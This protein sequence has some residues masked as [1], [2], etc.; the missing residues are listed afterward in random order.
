[1]SN[2]VVLGSGAW[3][4]ALAMHLSR[5][6]CGSIKL[7]SRS[8]DVC[9]T[10]SN[11]RE[12]L[13]YLPGYRLAD[14][15]DVQSQLSLVLEKVDTI[16]LAVPSQA[17]VGVVDQVLNIL[18]QPD[19]L[20]WVVATKGLAHIQ[21][22]HMLISDYLSDV[23]IPTEKIAFLSG[24]C[25]AAELAAGMFSAMVCATV[26]VR[27]KE[28][29]SQLFAGDDMIIDVSDDLIGLQWCA[30]YKNIIAIANGILSE[31]MPS[32]NAQAWL[33]T[34]GLGEMLDF[35]PAMGGHRNTVCQL[36]G[37]GDLVLTTTG[38]MSRNKR[39][40]QALAKGM[41]PKQAETSIGQ[42]VEGTYA[43]KKVISL[44]QDLGLSLPL[45]E[46]MDKILSGECQVKSIIN[47]LN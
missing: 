2:V 9:Q 46:R 41:T 38:Q 12:N 21:G 5:Q 6:G 36:S 13:R 30:V 29:V 42:V 31:V 20:E 43:V 10:I 15:I 7:W 16:V 28:R 4:T 18:P 22:R 44:A 39:F 27:M 23:G 3:G 37:L 8:K 45:V 1:M 35:V 19:A 11:H 17:V 33:I 25:F 26:H 24:P 14:S 32:H 34:Q 40:G 47:G